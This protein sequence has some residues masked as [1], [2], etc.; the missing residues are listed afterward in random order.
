MAHNTETNNLSGATASERWKLIAIAAA[1]ALAGGSVYVVSRNQLPQTTDTPAPSTSVP[2]PKTV[3]ALGRLEPKGEIIKL[4]A[5]TSTNGNRV[6]RLLVKEGDRVKVGQ[7]IAILDNRD[8]LQ[9]DLNE[10]KE[11]VRVARAKL[12]QVK[13]GAKRGEILAQQ[14]EIERLESDRQGDI[15]AQAATVERLKAEVKNAE[16]E[17]RRYKSLFEG[18]GVSASQRDSKQLSL[19]TARE[20]LQEAQVNLRRKQSIRS[21]ELAAAKA[22]LDSIAEVRQ[23][24][25]NTAKTEVDR[26]IAAVTGAKAS[27]DRAYVK[28]PQDGV[29][30]KIYS[31]AGELVSSTDGIIDLGQ[32]DRMDAVAE[33]YQSD[34]I[35]LKTGQKVR[36]IGDS[37]P[38]ELHGIVERIGWQVQRQQVINT[39]P[40]ANIDS[41]IVEVHIALDAA[42]S[43]KAARLTN[44]QVQVSIE[45]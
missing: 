22:N 41:R 43:Q 10:A 8:R 17:D 20:S 39:D 40:S 44:L 26:A 35:K 45:Q 15:D 29:V 12:E 11:E 36:V 18:G 31:R 42:S 13:A 14:A 19:E 16:A 7:V 37:L 9:A 1:L 27:L 25:V 2:E 4:S 21:P 24:D 30:M 23:V 5:P 3:T 6:D 34:V 28:A 33:V 38:G 32:T